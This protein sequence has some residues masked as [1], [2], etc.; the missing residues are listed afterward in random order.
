EDQ[1]GAAVDIGVFAAA[2][3]G[4]RAGAGDLLTA[5]ERASIVPGLETVCVELAARFCVDVFEDSYFGWDSSR[6]P[7]RREHNLVRARGQLAL[8]RSVRDQASR[9]ASMI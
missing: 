4:Y 1:D 8:A 3:D 2:M 7:S 9:L 6:Y 5:A